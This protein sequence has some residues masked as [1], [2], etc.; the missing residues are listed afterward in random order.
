MRGEVG[1]DIMY[2]RD[3]ES[4]HIM[5]MKNVQ[6][7]LSLYC[8]LAASVNE[9]I[10]CSKISVMHPPRLM[11]LSVRAAGESV[12]LAGGDI[13]TVIFGLGANSTFGLLLGVGLSRST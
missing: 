4:N 2:K 6:L 3:R 9:R 10:F 8:F 1:F 11:H 13:F 5:H 12:G 7:F